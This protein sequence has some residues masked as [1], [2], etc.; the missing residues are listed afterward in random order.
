[1]SSD[2]VGGDRRMQYLPFQKHVSSGGRQAHVDFRRGQLRPERKNLYSLTT[3]VLQR[4][5]IRA[6]FAEP[7]MFHRMRVV[8]ISDSAIRFLTAPGFSLK[9]KQFPTGD[10]SKCC[11]TAGVC[12]FR[13]Q[14]YKHS[15]LR[16]FNSAAVPFSIAELRTF[17]LVSHQVPTGKLFF[18]ASC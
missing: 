18:V 12:A 5:Q 9:S 1:L 15:P 14:V 13:V 11:C 17:A 8:S 2:W 4:V 7:E 16:S 3:P 6:P 10:P